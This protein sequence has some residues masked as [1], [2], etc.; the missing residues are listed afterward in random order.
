M[1]LDLALRVIIAM[2]QDSRSK[3]E[4]LTS[5]RALDWRLVRTVVHRSVPP[6]HSLGVAS[7]PNDQYGDLPGSV[8]VARAP[9]LHSLKGSGYLY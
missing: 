6:H 1:N 7:E 3:F 5:H 9:R 2:C 8:L 4:R